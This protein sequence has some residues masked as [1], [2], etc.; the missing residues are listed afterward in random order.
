MRRKKFKIE[1]DSLIWREE[2]GNRNRLLDLAGRNRQ[3]KLSPHYFGGKKFKTE[4]EVCP[5]PHSIQ[6]AMQQCN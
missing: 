1:I 2:I 3:E 4:I 5:S 6:E